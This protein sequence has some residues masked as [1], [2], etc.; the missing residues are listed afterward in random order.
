[1]GIGNVIRQGAKA[2]AKQ[3]GKAASL[4]YG[5]KAE[6]G[7]Q[8]TKLEVATAKSLIKK[9]EAGPAFRNMYT[10][11]N[12]KK[13]PHAVV[14]AAG[15]AYVGGAAM[16]GNQSGPFQG[17]STRGQKLG[18]VSYGG[19]PAVMDADG[20]GSKTKAPTLGATG[21]L[22]LGLHNSRKG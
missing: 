13:A 14:G 18:E 10:G 4:A 12:M 16:F 1:M 19:T 3:V 17:I 21:D 8:L 2:G 20:V 7:A 5:V 15:L 11:Y 22:V 6:A 9:D